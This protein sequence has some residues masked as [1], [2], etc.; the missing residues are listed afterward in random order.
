MLDSKLSQ[1]L[2]SECLNLAADCMQLG[3]SRLGESLEQ[4]IHRHAAVSALVPDQNTRQKF[5][6]ECLRAAADCME[7]AGEVHDPEL[8]RHFLARA[9][10]LTAATEKST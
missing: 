5:D 4:E 8:Q 7:L 6:L 10:Q 2:D 3:S 1:L 9:R